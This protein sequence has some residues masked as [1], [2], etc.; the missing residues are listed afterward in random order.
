MKVVLE[1]DQR[2]PL[3]RLIYFDFFFQVSTKVTKDF[4]Y[5]IFYQL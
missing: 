5:L 1:C 3:N 4:D 2:L